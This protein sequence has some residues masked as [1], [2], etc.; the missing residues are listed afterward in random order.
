MT[1]MPGSLGW[2]FSGPLLACDVVGVDEESCVRAF[3]VC[4]SA[5]RGGA[6]KAGKAGYC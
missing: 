3:G 5:K 2:G 1:R 4:V 6:G